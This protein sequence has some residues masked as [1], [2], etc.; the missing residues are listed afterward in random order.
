MCK[1]F[2]GEKGFSLLEFILV[3]ILGSLLAI[4]TANMM[5]NNFSSYAFSANSHAS[6]A[7]CRNAIN[8]MVLEL[9][10]LDSNAITNISANKI[11]FIDG[12]S[13]P[14]SFELSVGPQGLS[15]LRKNIPIINSIDSFTITYYDSIGNELAPDPAQINNIRRIGLDIVTAPIGEEGQT[16]IHTTI[17]PRSFIGLMDFDHRAQDE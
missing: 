9:V 2:L 16:N 8:R 10:E 3:M 12:D 7:N 1:F 5:L 13:N 6:L 4:P 11:E 17:V 14:A 15:V